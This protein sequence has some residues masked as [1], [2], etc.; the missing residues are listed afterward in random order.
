MRASVRLLS[1][2]YS[3]KRGSCARHHCMD[4]VHRRHEQQRALGIPRADLFRDQNVAAVAAATN[5]TGCETVHRISGLSTTVREEVFLL[6]LISLPRPRLPGPGRKSF[7]A[8]APA[9]CVGG[10]LD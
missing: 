10:G 8:R 2:A 9:A 7:A 6:N 3:R 4:R 5:A 1:A